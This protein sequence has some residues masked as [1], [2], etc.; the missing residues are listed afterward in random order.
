MDILAETSHGF[1][2]QIVAWICESSHVFS[3]HRMDLRTETSHGFADLIIAWILRTETSHG[4]AGQNRRKDLRARSSHGYAI[5]GTRPCKE[6]KASVGQNPAYP[7]FGPHRARPRFWFVF[8]VP[9]VRG[10]L[11]GFVSPGTGGFERGL[12][13]GSGR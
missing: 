7:H 11:S 8:G 10:A 1:A 5:P 12:S 9:P 13:Q 6:C 4:Y 3:S 2:G